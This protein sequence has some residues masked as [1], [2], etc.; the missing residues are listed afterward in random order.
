VVLNAQKAGEHALTRTVL[1]P[2]GVRV[3]ID[4]SLTHTFIANA[5]VENSNVVVH[6]EYFEDPE[7]KRGA[8]ATI[9]GDTTPELK[10]SV[11]ILRGSF[12]IALPA[13][14]VSVLPPKDTPDSIVRRPTNLRPKER[15]PNLP[16]LQF[17]SA[18]S[19]HVLA[20]QPIAS[21]PQ[22]ERFRWS[23]HEAA[24]AKRVAEFRSHWSWAPFVLLGSQFVYQTPAYLRRSDQALKEEPKKIRA[25]QLSG[26]ELWARPVRDTAYRGPFPH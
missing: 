15:L 21:D 4:D 1:L 16:E 22:W 10:S 9:L 3:T 13:G 7:R 11:Q 8:P 18:D 20:I 6:W 23:V 17:R 26:K 5:H 14:V 2:A 24:T 25:A 12:R 19:L